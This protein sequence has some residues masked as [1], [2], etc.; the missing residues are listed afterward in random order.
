VIPLA[1]DEKNAEAQKRSE[2]ARKAAATRKRNQEAAEKTQGSGQ[3]TSPPEPHTA[4]EPQEKADREND[5]IPAKFRQENLDVDR[6]QW[7]DRREP[8]PEE[9]LAEL[10]EAQ[11]VHAQR[12]GGGEVLEN[13]LVA[14]LEAHNERTGD[15][16]R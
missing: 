12:T 4:E 5:Q 6:S 3:S 13:E 14:Q 1:E 10:E 16:S 2:A 7:A 9:R 11:R 15:V 8:T